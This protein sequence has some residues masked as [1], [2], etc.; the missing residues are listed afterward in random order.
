LRSKVTVV[1][2]VALPSFKSTFRLY[3]PCAKLLVERLKMY[4]PVVASPR[5][6]W[7]PEC[8]GSSTRVSFTV[9]SGWLSI[10]VIEK[11]ALA[12]VIGVEPQARKNLRGTVLPSLK[13]L[14]GVLPSSR[15]RSYWR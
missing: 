3:V 11:V 12:L 14:L 5:R 10:F 8:A 15:S 13:T 1:S 4:W 9:P 7:L 6:N 2:R